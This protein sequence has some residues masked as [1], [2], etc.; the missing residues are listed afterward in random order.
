MATEN[1]SSEGWSLDQ[2]GVLS[3][4]K[5]ISDM[6]SD[7]L[8]S[9][10]FQLFVVFC[11]MLLL[12][13]VYDL[14][15]SKGKPGAW[16]ELH[17]FANVITV[18][19][20]TPAVLFWIADPIGSV[21]SHKNPSPDVLGDNWTHPDVILHPSNHI[22][23]LMILA[24]HTYHCIA[25]PLS[26][27]DMFH[28]FVFVPV[29]GFYGAF[30]VKWGPI[31]NV[32]SF[33]ISGLPGGIDYIIL[34]LMKRGHCS[35][36]FQKRVCAKINLWCRGP[37]VGILVPA[38]VYMGWLHGDITGIAD[39]VQMFTIAIFS[40]FNGIHYMEMA[41]KNYQMHL[42]KASMTKQHMQYMAS[43]TDKLEEREQVVYQEYWEVK[44]SAT[45]QS[46]GMDI[47]EIIESL[48]SPPEGPHKAFR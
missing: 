9:P 25:F 39:T 4:A 3:S 12:L 14:L 47:R 44:E 21:S 45:K 26:K 15:F 48:S 22:P 34:A 24:I 29:I 32:L 11:A 36:L 27:Q 31:R 23:C 41:I 42:T 28:H 10:D 46:P 37:A 20:A 6:G 5:Q 35:K 30:V 13:Y 7:L 19:F 17:A 18:I 2:L 38:T 40:C 8:L 33:F 43:L 1:V 16:F